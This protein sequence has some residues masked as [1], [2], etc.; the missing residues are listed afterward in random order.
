M[1]ARFALIPAAVLALSQPA[2]SLALQNQTFEVA[3]EK[4]Y[5]GQRLTPADFE[6]TPEQ[7]RRL[8][9]EYKVPAMR[10]KFK[11][12][13]TDD[14]NWL[15]L[16][17]VF[18]LNDVV[19]YLVA[20]DQSGKVLGIE[21]LTCAEGFCDNIMTPEWRAQLATKEHGKWD[22]REA[23]PIISGATYSCIHVI[24]GVKKMLAI[25]A[26]FLPQEAAP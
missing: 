8:K 3:Q 23:A 10:P 16:D 13:R 24:E 21:L 25:H 9:A 11:A 18:G 17:Q 14:G 19:T 4:L 20:I 1:R 7:F 15:F 22:V 12:W 26:R 6:L 5:P 2:P